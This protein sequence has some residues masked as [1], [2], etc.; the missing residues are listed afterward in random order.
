MPTLKNSGGMVGGISVKRPSA[1]AD[2][3]EREHVR[4]Y[5]GGRRGG[6][7]GGGG[8]AGRRRR[9]AQP[10]LTPPAY[11][12]CCCSTL[13]LVLLLYSITI[14]GFAASGITGDAESF[15]TLH[16]VPLGDQDL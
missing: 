14:G 5:H 7:R 2:G 1:E 16:R 13:L 4:G 15:T 8:D 6:R 9:H 12:C 10:E 3:G 11:A